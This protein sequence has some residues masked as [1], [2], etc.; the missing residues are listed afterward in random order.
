MS[1]RPLTYQVIE[2]EL[3]DTMAR[4]ENLTEQFAVAV[5]AKSEAE[6]AYK[7]A[8]AKARLQARYELASSGAKA[9]DQTTADT[10][11][12]ATE[13]EFKTYLISEAKYESLK[14]ALYSARERGDQIR[15]LMA[16]YRDVAG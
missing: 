14:Q 4:A 16:R 9:T 13:E 5:S 3:R 7:V 10:A 2:D 15:S 12:V 11:T 8:I 6:A 1:R